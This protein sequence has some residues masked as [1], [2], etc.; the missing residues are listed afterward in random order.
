[1]YVLK[2]RIYFMSNSPKKD[3]ERILS[4][5]FLEEIKRI[6]EEKNI[7][8][9]EISEKTNIKLS[10]IKAIESGNI[11]N[12]PGGIY[13]RAYIRSISEFLG[14]NTK[15]FE[16]KVHAS[17]EFVNDQKIKLEIGN[18][19]NSHN[20]NRSVLAICVTLILITYL[21]F[22]FGYSK[23]ESDLED[24]KIS[25]LLEN[26]GNS[27][28]A[29]NEITTSPL[30]YIDSQYKNKDFTISIIAKEQTQVEISDGNDEIV[31]SKIFLPNETVIY[32][33]DDKEY[34]LF[35]P[36]IGVLEIYLDGVFVENMPEM[37][38]KEDKF[39]FTVDAL[40]NAI[41]ENNKANT[42]LTKLSAE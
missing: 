8:Q 6:R 26:E 27:T 1:M 15:P 16:K 2:F 24:T 19:L 31:F 20:P 40:F 18:N 38:K 28:D 13:N 25:E 32:P 4:S 23:T 34:Y 21:I 39:I 42:K 41:E 17:D 9:E 29:Q 11:D 14:I 36:E 22:Y 12:L 35:T 5:E 10:Y 37:E 7:T 33:A 30:K 3:E